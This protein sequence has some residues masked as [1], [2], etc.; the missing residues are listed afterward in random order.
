MADV[1][2]EHTI[3]GYFYPPAENNEYV[4]FSTFLKISN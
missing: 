1:T 4:N 2:N 3:F